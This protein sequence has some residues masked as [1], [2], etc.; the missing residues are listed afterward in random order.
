MFGPGVEQ[1][2]EMYRNAKDDPELLG[3]LMLFGVDRADH[4]TPGT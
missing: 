1:A 2:I 3:L 4:A